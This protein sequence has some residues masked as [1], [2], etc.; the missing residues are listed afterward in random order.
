MKKLFLLII[1]VSILSGCTSLKTPE[2]RGVVVD[3]E[4]KKPVEGAW[5]S[6]TLSIKTKTIG[7]DVSSYLSVDPPHTRTDKEGKFVIPAKKFK[8]P[9]FPV[10]FGTKAESFGIGAS[11]IDDKAGDIS[12]IERGGRVGLDN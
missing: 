10:G 3:A 8:A 7:G 1:A 4:T 6:S 11:T 12:L 5:I 2:I 9:P